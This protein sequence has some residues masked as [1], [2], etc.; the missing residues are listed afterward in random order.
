MRTVA[1]TTF[2]LAHRARWGNERG[3]SAS[4]PCSQ[5]APAQTVLASGRGASWRA[6][7]GR[8][9]RTRAVQVMQAV[10]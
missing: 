4:L 8:V 1:C 7:G 6:W 2:L 9:R 5:S 3:G 10:L